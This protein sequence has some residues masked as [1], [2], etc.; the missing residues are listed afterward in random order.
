[1]KVTAFHVIRPEY[2]ASQSTNLQWIIDAHVACKD[3]S[4]QEIKGRLSKIDTQI[5]NRSTPFEEVFRLWNLEM[6]DK[7]IAYAKKSDRLFHAFYPANSL[8]PEHLIHVTCTGYVSPSGAQKI[9]AIHSPKTIVTHAYHMGCYAS[10]PALRMAKGF[11]SKVDIIHTEMCSLHLNPNNHSMEQLVIQ[12]LFADG[13]IKYSV[14]SE[15]KEPH[16]VIEALHEEIIPDTLHMM[17]WSVANSRFQM[18]LT[19]EIPVMLTKALHSFL[20]NLSDEL[21]G[22]YFAI[23][24]GGPKI[25]QQI[26]KV[27]GLQSWQYAHSLQVLHDYGNMS[28]A[29]LPHI[30]DRML[31]DTNIPHNSKVISLAFG[32]GLSISGAL[33][34]KIS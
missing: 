10:L 21:T 14:V 23:H 13:F 11:R 7:M 22:A 28:S 5:K 19:K 15:T 6:E 26:G 8:M 17:S 4:E 1:M 24:P 18:V 12:S 34:S 31:R 16:F 30:W 20:A 32:P 3:I 29:T 9:A 25:I 33:F 27:L 2:E